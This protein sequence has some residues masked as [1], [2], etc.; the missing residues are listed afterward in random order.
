M[1]EVSIYRKTMISL[2]PLFVII[3]LT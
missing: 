3:S 2:L 1:L